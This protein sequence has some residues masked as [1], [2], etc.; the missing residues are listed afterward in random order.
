[1]NGSVRRRGAG[2][3]YYYREL[4]PGTGRWRQRSKGGFA[5]RREAETALRAVLTTMDSGNYVSPSSLS[6]GDYLVHRWLP[7]IKTTI[8]ASTHASYARIVRLHI[9]PRLGAVKLQ[10]LDPM[11]LNEFY[12][13][14]LRD[15]R[16]LGEGGLSVRTVR[17]VHAVLHRAL[18]DAMRWQLLT[19]NVTEAA[20]P[21]KEGTVARPMMRT[22]SAE[23]LRSFLAACEG[24]R[25]H[26]AWLLL[27]STGMRRGEVLGLSWDDVDLETAQLAVRR[28]LVAVDMDVAFSEPKTQRSRRVVALDATTVAALRSWRRRQAEDKLAL[29]P[30]YDDRGFVF[31]R[32]DGR[33]FDPNDF[34][35]EFDRRVKRLGLPRIRLHDLRHTWATLALQAGIH[36]KVVSERL[37]HSTIAIT[38]DIYSHVTPT[39]QREAA[40]VVAGV[41]FGGC[42]HAG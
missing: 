5:S 38:L 9:V 16:A 12:A 31:T 18:R 34:S 4:N 1:M 29:G 24:D 37:G 11:M 19:R 3:E 27:A 41:I 20:D 8:R 6:L 2:W 42:T 21:P 17:Y 32:A 35:R 36:P 26:P 33:P 7:S 10:A 39:L 30:A 28:T 14:L 15:G 13:A 40:D 23:T 22:W 25:K